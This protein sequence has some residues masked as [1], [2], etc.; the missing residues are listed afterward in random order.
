MKTYA[1]MRE[2]AI[3]RKGEAELEAHMPTPPETPL[4]EWSDDRLLAEFSRRVFQAGFNWKVIDTKWPGFEAGFHGFDIHRNAMMSDEDLDAHL[5]DT[6]IVR[7][8]AKILSVRDNAVFLSD[9]AK[10]HG[11]AARYIGTWPREDTVGLF[12]L[13]K[14]RGSRLGGATGQY[15]LRFA[16]YGNFILSKS[17]VAALNRAGVIEGAATSKSALAKV[18][19][20]FNQWAEESG[21]SH[22]RISRVLAFS[23]PD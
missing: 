8:A 15:A 12:E 4:A 10:E 11:S 2:M 7:H 14:K 23:V 13:L 20:A 6:G 3:A 18:Q 1:E 9:L 17:V 21:E 22:A 5:R 19:A 16:G